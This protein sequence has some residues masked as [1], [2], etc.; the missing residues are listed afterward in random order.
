MFSTLKLLAK[1]LVSETK[2][3]WKPRVAGQAW[4][5]EQAVQACSDHDLE[6]LKRCLSAGLDIESVSQQGTDSRPRPLTLL[7]LTAHW[8]FEEGLDLLLSRG[9]EP[10]GRSES[11]DHGRTPLR[12]ML[13]H[14]IEDRVL[15]MARR[16]I[17]GGARLD[18][19]SFVL[20]ASGPRAW[21]TFPESLASCSENKQEAWAPVVAWA[22]VVRRKRA[23]E[24]G[25]PVACDA[26]LR[27]ARF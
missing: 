17:D 6:T 12:T 24:Q 25:L 23:L 19:R 18:A 21:L 7:G 27:P 22:E 8:G 3:R 2:A 15:R 10:N 11:M 13:D 14:V 9:A 5:L 26:V 1:R 20:P 4:L 16:L